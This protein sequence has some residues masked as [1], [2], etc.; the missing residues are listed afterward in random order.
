[1]LYYKPS[2]EFRAKEGGTLNESPAQS[3]QSV[4]HVA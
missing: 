2:L 3:E 1:M 4:H